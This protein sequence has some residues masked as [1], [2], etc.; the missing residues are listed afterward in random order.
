MDSETLF[1]KLKS[2]GVSVGTGHLANEKME[3]DDRFNI[4]N[5]IH[6]SNFSTEFGQV[7]LTTENYPLSYLHGEKP[8]YTNQKM[9]ILAAWNR[10]P[11]LTDPG[12]YKMVFLDTETSGLNGGAG[13]FAFLVGIGY[14]T[15]TG[16]ELIQLFLR[17]PVEEPAL[18]AALDYWLSMFNVVITFNGKSFDIPLLNMRYQING[19]S[20]PFLKYDQIDV[21]QISRKIW[22][23]RLASRAL[24]D[25]EKEILRFHRTSEDIPG[26]MIPQMY[27]DYLRTRNARPLAGIFYHNAIDILSLATLFGVTVSLIS[28]PL[29]GENTFGIDLAAIAKIYEEMGRL[30]QAAVIYQRSLEQG[31]LPENFFTRTIERYAHLNKQQKN[32]NYAVE[33]WNIGANH[34]SVLACVEL[35]KYYEHHVQNY[36]ESMTWAK[37]ALENLENLDTFDHP[38]K[39]LEEDIQI[40]IGRLSKRIYR[41]FEK[42]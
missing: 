20:T 23:D 19:L 13:V 32:W 37:K 28:D 26:W 3:R 1:R 18:L 16:F 4:E 39:T 34:G 22:R 17:D 29:Q 10:L 14:C 6:G 12:G 30:D 15:E 25:L 36:A 27:F 41:E 21:L 42:R 5:V 33:L 9:D 40:R 7:F 35:S 24:G 8:V 11:R 31:N 2:L 38:Q